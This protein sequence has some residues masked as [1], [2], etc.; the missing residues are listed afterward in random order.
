MLQD[1]GGCGQFYM[2]SGSLREAQRAGWSKSLRFRSPAVSITS[3]THTLP[4]PPS[5]KGNPD[6]LTNAINEAGSWAGWGRESV[7]RPPLQRAPEPRSEPGSFYTPLVKL[8]GPSGR[9]LQRRSNH[10]DRLR[11][12]WFCRFPPGSCGGVGRR[13]HH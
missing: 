10:T 7:P 11:G 1:P 4:L 8:M 12:H 6:D 3:N 9:A 13:G 2:M 5:P